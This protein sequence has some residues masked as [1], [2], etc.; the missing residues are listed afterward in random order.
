MLTHRFFHYLLKNQVLFALFIIASAWLLLQ[1]RDIILLLFLSYIIM[2][3]LL[4]YVRYLRKKHFPKALAVAIPY[5]SMVIGILLLIVPLV[6]VFSQIQTLVGDFPVYLKQA[7]QT[8][9]I[10]IE[11]KQIQE[12][13]TN[14]L[15][16]IS[17]NALIVTTKVFGGIFSL[18]AI[19]IISFYLLLYY[20]EFKRL[21]SRLFHQDK[22]PFVLDTLDTI[23]EKL[24]AWMRG[25]IILM[26]F[27]GLMSWI[28]LTLLGIK[29]ALPLALLAGLLEIVP[30]LGPIMS[31]IPAVIVALTISPTLALPVA[32]AYTIIQIIENNFLVPKIM[33][34]AVGLNPVVIIL[35]VMIGI[36]LMGIAGG[37]LAIPLISFILVIFKSLE[38]KKSQ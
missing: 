19:F 33:E 21:F 7:A 14:E 17:K 36:N 10:S 23:N 27:I 20:D 4:P 13:I 34:K 5:F 32:L 18:L 12:F 6:P 24:G 11:P 29:F 26:F 31:A 3:S 9:S 37:L 25:E 16:L 22:R 8:F 30:T 28:T 38:Q 1:I 2:S 15:N 35:G